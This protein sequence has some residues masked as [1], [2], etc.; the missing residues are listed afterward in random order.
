METLF[1]AAPR[2]LPR[3]R[4]NDVMKYS[5]RTLFIVLTIIAVIL[6]RVAYLR[7]WAAFHE[8][9]EARYAWKVE[10]NSSPHESFEWVDDVR[11]FKLHRLLSDRY[12]QASYRPWTFV[13]ETPPPEDP[14]VFL[15]TQP[16]LPLSPGSA[17][18]FG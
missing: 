9:E 8:R 5:L 3:F 18:P 13:D 14:P 16:E 12:R 2:A 15:K 6:S 17:D 7:H 10:S 11:E 1:F 4:Y